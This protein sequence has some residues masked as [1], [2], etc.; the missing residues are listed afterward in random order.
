MR[1]K[2]SLLWFSLLILVISGAAY[3]MLNNSGSKNGVDGT[4]NSDV[5]TVKM[6]VS[7][8]NYILE[9]STVKK[10]TLVRIEADMS[11]MPG[12]SKS[13]VIQAFGVRKVLGSNSNTI[14]FTPTKS[15]TFTIA[16]SMNMYRG[17]FT[18]TD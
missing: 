6:K 10:G 11:K 7:G 3:A 18:V 13:V 17:T 16:C 1:V 15:G 14:E 4:V 9:P 8:A 12:C 2:K 5:Q